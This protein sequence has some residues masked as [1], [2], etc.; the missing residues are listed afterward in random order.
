MIIH[1]EFQ[2]AIF[3]DC[4]YGCGYWSKHLRYDVQ[5]RYLFKVVM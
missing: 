4:D 2:H 3:Y 5:I 1:V